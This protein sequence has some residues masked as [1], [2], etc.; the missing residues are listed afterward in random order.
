MKYLCKKLILFYKR[1]ISPALGAS[2]IYTPTCSMYTYDAIEN[3]RRG[4]RHIERRQKDF[5][6]QPFHERRV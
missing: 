6:M 1:F 5:K 4:Q 3:I 2:C